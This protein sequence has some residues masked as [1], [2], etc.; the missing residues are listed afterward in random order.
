MRALIPLLLLIAPSVAMADTYRCT[1]D[2][3]TVYSDK[4]C[5]AAATKVPI[6]ADPNAPVR[7][8]FTP[9][10]ELAIQE[11]VI[12]ACYE[13]WRALA[14]DPTT[15]KMLGVSTR[16]PPAGIPI[17]RISAVFT[18]KFGG[19]ERQELWCKI[20]DDLQSVDQVET[21]KSQDAFMS[22]R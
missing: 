16:V 6:A 12:R 5:G 17:V 13:S 9:G 22:S 1:Q 7:G 19:P 14:R 8:K 21:R 10:A 3:K 18:N 15:T 4:P 2:G 20:T 11:H